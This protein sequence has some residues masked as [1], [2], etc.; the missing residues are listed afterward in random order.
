MKLIKKN[1]KIL[2]SFI[3]MFDNVDKSL[4]L[5]DIFKNVKITKYDLNNKKLLTLNT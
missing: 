4:I 2:K 5:Q 3:Q 1:S